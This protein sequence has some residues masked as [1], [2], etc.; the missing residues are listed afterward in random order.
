MIR[1]TIELLPF[2]YEKNKKTLGTAIISNTGTGT[3]SKGNYKFKLMNK[4]KSRTWKEGK[5]YDFP[6]LSLNVWHLLY[7]VLKEAFDNKKEE[8]NESKK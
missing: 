3:L 7:R 2:G 4:M 6:R 5:I 1:V 8:K